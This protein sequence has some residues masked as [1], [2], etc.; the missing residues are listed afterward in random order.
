MRQSEVVAL[1]GGAPRGVVGVRVVSRA[2]GERK[3]EEID[4]RHVI[5]TTGGFAADFTNSS[6]LKQFRP[7]R[8][9]AR[10][11]QGITTTT[12]PPRGALEVKALTRRM[13][14]L[15]ER[16]ATTNGRWAT[17]DGIKLAMTAGAATVDLQDVQVRARTS[18]ARDCGSRTG[19]GA[20]VHPTAFVDPTDPTA[21]RKTLCAE[22]LR[23][24]G[25]ILLDKAGKRFADELG[26]RDYLVRRPKLR[27]PGPPARGAHRPRVPVAGGSHAAN[28]TGPAALHT[29]A[30]GRHGRRGQPARAALRQE[31]AAA[32]LRLSGGAGGL[33]W[34]GPRNSVAEPDGLQRGCGRGR[35]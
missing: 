2:G 8:T 18:A 23:G 10:G 33:D 16:P 30:L 14:D 35:R 1:V 27:W 32:P 26:T 15:L 25:G 4:A 9:C 17:G 13:Q 29:G 12:T 6:L 11:D 21:E 31:R 22:I 24:V 19:G 7:V 5:I 3:T 28:G 20:Q 34:R